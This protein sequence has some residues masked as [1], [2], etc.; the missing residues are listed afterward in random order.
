MTS[1]FTVAIHIL[2]LLSLGEGKTRTSEELAESVN[3]NPVVIRKILSLLKNQG[4]VRNQMGPNGG[5]YLAKP[6]TEINL[7]EIYEAIDEKIFQMHSK[8]PNKKCICGHAIQPILTKVYDKAQKVLE[9]EL[10][11]TNLDSITREILSFSKR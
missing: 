11:S 3:T 1:R 9:E 8:S 2:S 10:G 7:K 4:I 6:A 5:Y